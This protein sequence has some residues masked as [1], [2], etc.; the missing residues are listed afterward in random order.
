VSPG[1]R[2]GTLVYIPIQH[3]TPRKDNPL[4]DDH[5]PQPSPTSAG[6]VRV[7][8]LN[9]NTPVLVDGEP[10]DVAASQKVFNHSPDGFAWGYNGSGPAQLALAIL[11]RHT[12]SDTALRLHQHFKQDFVARWPQAGPLNEQIPLRDWLAA[13]ATS[14]DHLA[15]DEQVVRMHMNRPRPG[16]TTDHPEETDDN[17]TRPSASDRSPSRAT[18]TPASRPGPGG[19]VRDPRQPNPPQQSHQASAHMPT[20]TPNI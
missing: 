16:V 20:A 1:S 19:V 7:Q 4:P 14:N 13:H 9:W 10:L 17:P 5:S 2:T 6:L 15:N 3:T 12:D 8:A 11:L 18:D